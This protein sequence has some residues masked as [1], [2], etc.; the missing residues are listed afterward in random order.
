MIRPRWRIERQLP[1]GAWGAYLMRYQS[2]GEARSSLD[3]SPKIP[4]VKRRIN[5]DIYKGLHD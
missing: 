2:I 4:G 5:I 3:A 1:D